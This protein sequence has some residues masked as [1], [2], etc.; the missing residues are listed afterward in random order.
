MIGKDLR[1]AAG[2]ALQ[3]PFQVLVQVTNR[4]NMKCSFCDFWPNGAPP[5]EELTTDEYRGIART[6]SI[7]GTFLVSIEGGEP[8]LR[9]DLVDIVGAFAS[10]GHLPVLYTN[11]WF[12][13]AAKAK[14]LFDAGLTNVGVSIDFP[15]PA[16]HDAK[17]GLPMTWARAW[18]AV[19]C[20][21]DAAPKGGRQVHVMTVFMKENQHDLEALLELSK[22]AGVGHSI[23]LLSR[24]GFRR[25]ENDAD[26][27]PDESVTPRLEALWRRFPH[28][29]VFGDYLSGFDEFLQKRS[30][31][32][33]RAG[34]QSFNIDHLGNVS[35]CIEKID[36]AEGNLRSKPLASLLL[37]M[38]HR[39]DVE[40]CQ[41]CWTLCRGFSQFLGEGGSLPAWRDLAFRMRSG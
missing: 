10:A 32:V 13:D 6:L 38:K 40:S 19:S 36:Q 39:P 41:K 7:L 3:R 37:S 28:F 20:F 31:P 23:T 16:R 21:K 15:D 24:E 34:R 9:A 35:P 4:C 18:N 1:F 5:R 8:F 14:A 22:A 11:G 33:C 17:R 27:W 29:R 30:L 2:I 25:V 12:V 26:Q